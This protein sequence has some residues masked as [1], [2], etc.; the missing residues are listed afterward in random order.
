[1]GVKGKR[2]E[3]SGMGGRSRTMA[4]SGPTDLLFVL[5]STFSAALVVLY[6][7]ST[8]RNLHILGA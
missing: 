6:I 4:G 5:R 8:M 1:M 3:K 2:V 7:V